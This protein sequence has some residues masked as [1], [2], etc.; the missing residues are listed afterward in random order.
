[1][2]SLK[3]V[4]VPITNQKDLKLIIAEYLHLNP[5]KILSYK[6]HKESIDARPKHEFCYIYEFYVELANEEKYLLNKSI[7]KVTD[8]NY[9]FPSIGSEKVSK[10]PI[11]IGAG[12]AGLFATYML[13]KHGYKPILFERGKSIDERIKDVASFWNTGVLLKIPMCNLEKG[14]LGLFLMVN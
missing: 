7:T 11:V 6:I 2:L 3:N 8:E 12:P 9:I 1:M 14:A 13:A 10:R 5:N 4:K